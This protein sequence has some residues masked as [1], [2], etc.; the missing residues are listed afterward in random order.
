VV[1]ENRQPGQGS[2]VTGL[3]RGWADWPATPAGSTQACAWIGAATTQVT[4]NRAV[5]TV[6]GQ[7]SR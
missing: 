4:I 2:R 7:R 5:A 6:R 3:E 1:V